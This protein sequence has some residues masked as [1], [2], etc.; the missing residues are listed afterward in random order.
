MV[1]AAITPVT[2]PMELGGVA[3]ALFGGLTLGGLVT[4]FDDMVELFRPTAKTSDAARS[5][6]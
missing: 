6:L 5:L 3:V 1:G 4:V 2:G